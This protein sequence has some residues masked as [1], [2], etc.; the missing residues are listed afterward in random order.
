[1]HDVAIIGGGP[2][3]YV[4]AIHAAQHGLKAL[5]IEKHRLGGTC[6]NSGCIPTKCFIHDT[7]LFRMAKQS[8]VLKGANALGFDAAEML[9]RKRQVVDNLVA[10]L[11]A[12]VQHHQIEIVHGRGVLAAPGSVIVKRPDGT[13][14]TRPAR[15]IILANGSKPALPPFVA[16]DGH[17]VQTTDQALETADI[18]ENLVI[19]GG[20]VIG[21]EMAAIYLNLGVDV[22]IIELLPDILIG[23]DRDIRLGMRRLLKKSG[24][25]LLLSTKVGQITLKGKHIEIIIEDSSGQS[26]AL[27]GERVLVATGR[28]PVLD[29]I[30]PVQL[31][32]EMNGS[33]VKTDE[34]LQTN[35]PRVYAIGDLIG[36]VMLA[37]KASADA[38][39]AVAH[40]LGDLRTRGP[41][42]IPRCI[43]GIS[44]IGSI[45]LTEE[46]LKNTGRRFETGKFYF[47]GGSAAMA[48]N[49]PEGFVKILGDAESGEIFGVHILG[50][51][52][53]DIIAG[54]A[55]ALQSGAKVQDLARTI[56][57]HPTL[58]EALTEAA[59][60][61]SGQAIH[62]MRRR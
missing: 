62:K 24:A 44:E 31:Q 20:G 22:T 15:N 41:R 49:H 48:M 10:G 26:K 51:Q 56:T 3:G 12:L 16:I 35:L 39:T 47:A 45:G 34:Y 13:S 46:D 1:M 61:I 2:G 23:E 8:S 54:V 9:S 36:G 4:A 21:I 19:I 37:H 52:A 59:R 14:E 17:F 58:S 18:P 55:G 40:I 33:F 53:T 5:L 6:L 57:P 60:D 25:T 32:L 42:R 28:A 43:W 50:E 7:R 27:A 11:Q 29:G 30:D 38:E